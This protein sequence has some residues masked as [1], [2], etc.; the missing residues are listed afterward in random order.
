MKAL[1]PKKADTS[2]SQALSEI[3]TNITPQPSSDGAYFASHTNTCNQVKQS[4]PFSQHSQTKMKMLVAFSYIGGK[5]PILNFL[6]QLLPEQ[7]EVFCEPFCG[8][9]RVLLNR[10]PANTE[11]INDID[12]NITLFFHTIQDPE[13]FKQFKY[14]IERTPYSLKE[15]SL[16]LHQRT[17][18]TAW[19]IA[20]LQSLGSRGLSPKARPSSWGRRLTP[21]SKW[22]RWIAGLDLL[23]KRLQ[24][25]RIENRDATQCIK[26]WDS[27]NTVFY[28]DPPYPLATRYAQHVRYDHEMLD[29][30]HE[31][32]INLL[33]SCKARIALSSYPNKIYDQLLKYGWKRIDK[34]V[35]CNLVGRV[36]SLK[37]ANAISTHRRIECVYLNY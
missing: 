4:I 12:P 13:A 14:I 7:C 10:K 18:P 8:S 27:P 33:P 19:C 22:I 3:A 20:L 26:E 9:A 23:H 6:K 5:G 31:E 16:A 1:C 15:F 25:V 17:N 34:P 29:E 28:I 30:Q 24:H 36:G 11:I 35:A 2:P 32:L 37:G 21:D